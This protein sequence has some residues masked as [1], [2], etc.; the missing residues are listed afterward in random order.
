MN[1]LDR[2][3]SSIFKALAKSQERTPKRERAG[4]D[5]RQIR[6][7]ISEPGPGAILD[8][9]YR[10]IS[11]APGERRKLIASEAAGVVQDLRDRGFVDTASW[12]FA[13]WQVSLAEL[14]L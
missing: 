2:K 7:H 11:A 14:G 8:E 4:S 3:L 5:F 12:L 6:L 1:P 13:R 9:L 10:D